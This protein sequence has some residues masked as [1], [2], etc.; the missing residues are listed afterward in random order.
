MICV[1]LLAIKRGN[2]AGWLMVTSVREAN[3]D[4]GRKIK[5]CQLLQPGTAALQNEAFF[6]VTDYSLLCCD[7]SQITS[8]AENGHSFYSHGT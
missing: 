4:C 6:I 3:Q 2:A 8:C 7:G 5:R 1:E